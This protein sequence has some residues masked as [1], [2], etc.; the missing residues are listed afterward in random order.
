MMQSILRVTLEEG[1]YVGFN[2]ARTQLKLLYITIIHRR[3][4]GG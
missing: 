3:S 4:G 2:G 1:A